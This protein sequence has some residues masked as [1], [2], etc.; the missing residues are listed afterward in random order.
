VSA[1]SPA[2]DEA[3][4]ALARRR[5]VLDETTLARARAEGGSVVAML[6]RTKAVPQHDVA[7]VLRE[8][9]RLPFR[10]RACGEQ[11]SYDSLHGLETLECERCR[12]GLEPALPGK[13]GG[14]D[15]IGSYEVGRELG[16]GSMGVVYAAR[17]AGLD[18]GFA[19]KVMKDADADP[20]LMARF[21]READVASRIMHP[22]I[23]PVIDRGEH[24]GR[25]YYVME[26]APGPTLRARLDA[27]G[28]IPPQEAA[29]LVRD[30]ADAAAAAHAVGVI[31]RDLK[32]AN[33]ILEEPS[34]RPR[35]TDFGL[36]RDAFSGDKLTQSGDMIGTPF[37]MAPEQVR[38]ERDVD[39]RAD[40][41]ALGV[42]LYECLAGRRPFEARF[43]G[44][45]GKLILAGERRPLRELV[46][47]TPEGL[48]AI[49]LKAFSVSRAAR[50]RNATEL[51]EDL[52]RFLGGKRPHA[53]PPEERRERSWK[54]V[55]WAV[56]LLVFVAGLA[57]HLVRR[58]GEEE[59]A[60]RE[61]AAREEQ[62][63]QQ[64]REAA[65]RARREADEKRSK[66]EAASRAKSPDAAD[67]WQRA[68][69]AAPDALPTELGY[70]RFLLHRNHAAP[71][72]EA[73]RAILARPSLSREDSVEA[74][75]ILAEALLRARPP[76]LSAT[77][78]EL[79]K[80]AGDDAG[81]ARG[82]LAQARLAS[83]DGRLDDAL[84]AARASIAKEDLA[85]ARALY[86]RV[87]A[88]GF[89]PWR[90][91][92]RYVA[93][94][95]DRA[96][97][98]KDDALAEQALANADR[99]VELAPDDVDALE[100]RSIVVAYL[101]IFRW[102]ALGRVPAPPELRAFSAPRMPDLEEAVDLAGN[103][104]TTRSLILR[105]RYR[106]FMGRGADA[107]EDLDRALRA[108]PDDTE[109]L[110]IRAF[111]EGLERGNPVPWLRSAFA[112]DDRRAYALLR[113]ATIYSP[114]TARPFLDDAKVIFGAYRRERL[115]ELDGAYAKRVEARIAAATEVARKSIRDGIAA[116]R[117]GKPLEE[118][119][120]PFDAA[121][122][123][124][125]GD[126]AP[127]LELARLLAGRSRL[128]DAL[129]A[130]DE[131]RKLG[132]DPMTV[133]ALRGEA[134]LRAGRS[135]LARAQLETVAEAAEGTTKLLALAGAKRAAGDVEGARDAAARAVAAA[136]EDPDAHL[137]LAAALL[138]GDLGEP[139]AA[140]SEAAWAEDLEGWADVD[141]EA[142]ELT[143]AVLAPVIV[144][145]AGTS[146]L[147]KD[148]YRS[149]WEKID[150]MAPA[151]RLHVKTAL[152]FL[153]A[154]AHS[155]IRDMG[156]AELERAKALDPDGFDRLRRLL[157]DLDRLLG[158]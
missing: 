157:P 6:L 103:D 109:A 43:P 68:R 13:A 26:L 61:A 145:V 54:R 112:S 104:A 30:L 82:L 63:A 121:R 142:T 138:D 106:L 97:L 93:E 25:A 12:A 9:V 98:E 72:I 94:A 118:A 23:V 29:R 50:Y 115:S 113:H 114:E 131:A 40:V 139:D 47:E 133:G 36:A 134:L 31:H 150:R 41:Y 1:Q 69:S 156:R 5:G 51:K 3:F 66:A 80:L 34:G 87:L 120:I 28:K 46:K 119:R 147:N 53:L 85:P 127:A 108:V 83:L 65:A 39:E 99:A 100:A 42:I 57:A 107:R 27:R 136:P 128:D 141:V 4:V 19:I 11:W 45:L 110:I 89:E 77:R 79:A 91:M 8:L 71:A 32:P 90:A 37:Y 155:G 143:A 52:G 102:F 149:T 33:V 92:S 56:A 18:R 14:N 140:A 58:H 125:P 24:E 70:A 105:G 116:A 74:R 135:S 152:V 124:A 129:A 95:N 144:P 49:C 62:R 78:E 59:L 123:A 10:C 96:V 148:A 101:H 16:R 81:G 55:A 38:G 64:A 153:R 122:A 48:E 84:R 76:Q 75:S 111:L 44:E 2:Q 15:R 130:L 88:V 60:R 20:E 7:E 86:A 67:L 21:T 137:A 146:L 117:E 151:A 154:P 126:P 158:G 35:I 132:A 22:G 17:K 73:A